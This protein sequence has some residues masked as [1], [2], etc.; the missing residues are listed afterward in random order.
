MGFVKTVG[1]AIG[2]TEDVTGVTDQRRAAESAARTQAE[3][4]EAAILRQEEAAQRAQGF[5]EPFAGVAEQ[6]AAGASF[7][8]DPQERFDFLQSNPLF[9]LALENANQRTQQS[10]SA[11]RRLSFGDTLQQLSNNVLLS[12]QPLLATQDRNI[13]NLL[14][15]GSNIAGNRA[16]IE[17]GLGANVSDLTTGIG[18]SLSAGQIAAGGA[19]GQGFKNLIDITGAIGGV[20]TGGGFG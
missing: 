16:N 19:Q 2:L 4:G 6:G 10:A 14:G 8:T 7:L 11:N 20:A 5:F 9:E 1:A 3:S 15:I 18:S 13:T 12:S 17:T